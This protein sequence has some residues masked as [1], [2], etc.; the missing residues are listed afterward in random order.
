[1]ADQGNGGRPFRSFRVFDFPKTLVG[2]P[3]S[4]KH[5]AFFGNENPSNQYI[6][7]KI[8]FRQNKVNMQDSQVFQK[9]QE[10]ALRTK[11]VFGGSNDCYRLVDRDVAEVVVERYGPCLWVS[12]FREAA[13]TEGDLSWIGQLAQEAGCDHWLVNGMVDRGKDPGLEKRWQSPEFPGR[14][15][16]KE[17]SITFNLRVDTG[18]SPGLFLDQ[19]ANRKLL[20]NLSRNT[21]VLNLFAYTCSFSVVAALGGATQVTSVDVSQPFLDWGKENFTS[22][23]LPTEGHYFV[24]ADTRDYL[25]L[26]RKRGWLFNYIILDPPSFSRSKGNT[27]AVKKEL[28]PMAKNCLDLLVPGGEVLVSTNLSTWSPDDLRS[29]LKA[30]L[31]CQVRPGECEGDITDKVNSAKT[32]WLKRS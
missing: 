13:P 4:P 3:F 28:V 24:K 7:V 6:L 5:G 15:Q 1:M 30:G 19:R 2:D 20:R 25:T 26:A 27:F 22:N 11:T 32:F 31:R 9:I 18:L 16:S 23:G 29:E 12:W 14:W 21:K 10:R 8:R 17:N